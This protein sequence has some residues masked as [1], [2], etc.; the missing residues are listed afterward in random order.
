MFRHSKH[1]CQS[2]L[3]LPGCQSGVQTCDLCLSKQAALT[4]VPGLCFC[5]YHAMKKR[6]DESMLVY[7]WPTVYDGG[8]AITQHWFRVSHYCCTFLNLDLRT[9]MHNISLDIKIGGGGGGLPLCEMADAPF[10]I[11]GGDILPPNV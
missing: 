5:Q 3:S 4:T 2:L 1:C 6:N 8:P 7:G 11:Q 9:T 10:H